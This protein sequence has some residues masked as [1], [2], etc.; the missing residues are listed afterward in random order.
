MRKAGSAPGFTLIELIVA[1]AI[2][3]VLSALAYG[4]LT[5]VLDTRAQVTAHAAR[6]TRI[7]TALER[8]AQDLRLAAPR[9]VRDEFGD[10]LG[11][12]R[13]TGGRDPW[14]EFTRAGRD[15]PAGFPRSVLQRVAWSVRDGVLLRAAW[16]ELDRMQTSEPVRSE[17]L[18][19]VQNFDLRFLD[20][21]GK[22]LESWPPATDKPIPEFMPKLVEVRLTLDDFG[23][24]VRLYALPGT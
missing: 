20:P 6:F 23:E 1:I 7:Q 3:A 24:I 12:F 13:G 9:P 19:G 17:L 18:D 4:G 10:R 15:N 16:N 11:A 5:S 8:L 21:S 22:L 2:F 14:M